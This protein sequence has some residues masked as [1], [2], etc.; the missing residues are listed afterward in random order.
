MFGQRFERV[1]ESVKRAAGRS[2]SSV[3]DWGFFC[4]GQGR[5]R[6]QP[7]RIPRVEGRARINGSNGDH[8]RS[9]VSTTTSSALMPDQRTPES[10]V[11]QQSISLHSYLKYN[12]LS[13]S[14]CGSINSHCVHQYRRYDDQA[15]VSSPAVA[16]RTLKA[17]ALHIWCPSTTSVFC[18]EYLLY[19]VLRTVRGIGPWC[20]VTGSGRAANGGCGARTTYLEQLIARDISQI[21]TYVC[22]V[23]R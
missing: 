9:Y 22:T 10:F 8:C 23:G 15:L 19:S 11:Q 17:A 5:M 21:G 16:N 1:A 4:G 20:I 7:D 2:F 13:N 6:C 12:L 14:R 18:T 3:H